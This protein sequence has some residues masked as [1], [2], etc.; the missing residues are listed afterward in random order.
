MRPVKTALLCGAA[1]FALTASAAAR[2]SPMSTATA[3]DLIPHAL[4]RRDTFGVPHITADTD[5]AA[6][7]AMGYAVATSG[8]VASANNRRFCYI[9]TRKDLN[10]MVELVDAPEGGAAVWK[11][12]R[13]ATDAWDGRTDPI[14]IMGL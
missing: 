8:E 5:E 1:V 7:F 3:A 9:D 10:C 11:A 13:E 4:I 2:P 6:A 12:M 14:R